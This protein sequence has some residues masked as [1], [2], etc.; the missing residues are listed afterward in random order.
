MPSPG[1]TN[2]MG[3][4]PQQNTS[5]SNGNP[6]LRIAGLIIALFGVLLILSAV[7]LFIVQ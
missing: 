2:Q 5:T 7:I 1:M 3:Y 4:A 6:T